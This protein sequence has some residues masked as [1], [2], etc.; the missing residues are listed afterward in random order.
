MQISY[1]S[2]FL[3]PE[4]LHKLRSELGDFFAAL[5]KKDDK[6]TESD[7][8]HLLVYF[9]IVGNVIAWYIKADVQFS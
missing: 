6:F 2:I 7:L 5:C 9:L 1:L 8:M 3:Q 4:R